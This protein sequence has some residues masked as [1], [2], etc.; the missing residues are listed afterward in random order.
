MQRITSR[1]L[2]IPKYN[3]WKNYLDSIDWL[4]NI[5]NKKRSTLIQFDIIEFNLSITRELILKSLNHTWEYTDIT[6]EKIEI[7]LA[8][9]KLMLSDNRRTWV[10]S[11][12]DNFDVPMGTYDTARVAELLGIYILNTLGRI[13]NLQQVRLYGMTE[14]SS[15][16][17]VTAQDL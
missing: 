11:H 5:K 3:Q 14:L 2:S 12:V 17:T 8:W 6:D 7:I 10:K 13:V 15:S 9:T 4:K 1:L 16:R